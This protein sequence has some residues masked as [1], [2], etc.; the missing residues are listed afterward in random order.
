MWTTRN[1]AEHKDE[2]SRINMEHDEE[3]NMAI[4]DIYDRLPDILQILP[5]GDQQFFANKATY[6]KKRKLPGVVLTW[7]Q[8]KGQK[9]GM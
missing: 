5:H 1:E 4:Q 2:K 8:S 7:Y 3:V 6:R 9:Q